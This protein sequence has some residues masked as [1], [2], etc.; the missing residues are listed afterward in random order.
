MTHLSILFLA[1]TLGQAPAESGWLNSVPHDA[2][3]VVRVRGLV[4]AKTDLVAMLKA[5]SP[6]LGAQAEP[7]L[8]Q[9]VASAKAHANEQAVTEPFMMMLRAVAPENPGAPPFAVIVKSTNY[10][11]VLKSIAGGNDPGI[12]HLDAGYDSFNGP[13]GETWYAAKGEG[14]VGFGPD[15]TLVAGY[16]KPGDKALGKTISPAVQKKFNTGDIGLYVNINALTTRY[17]EQVA[18]AKQ[19]LLATMDQVG[20]QLGAG[21][22]DFLKSVYGGMFDSIKEADVIALSLELGAEGLGVTGTLTVKAD[23]KMIK[24]I[25]GIQTSDGAGLGK[26]PV[27]SAYYLYMNVDAKTFQ[28]LQV[29]AL[30]M[31]APGGKI[32]PELEATIA[33]ERGRIESVA[34]FSVGNG[35]KTFDVTNLTDPKSFVD[36]FNGT[37]KL[38]QAVDSPSNFYKDF[39]TTPN[40]ET[41][42]GFT[43]T[44]IEMTFDFEKLAKLMPNNPAG[45]EGMKAMYGGDKMTT[46]LGVSDTQMIKANA[47][48]WSD[49]KAQIDSY[50]KGDDGI[51][52]SAGFK[53]TRAKLP[54]QANI[55]VLISAQGLVRQIM[56]Q[57]AMMMPNAPKQA[58][59]DMPKDPAFIG[60]SLTPSAPNGFEFRLVIP[61]TVGP[62]IEKGI[63]PLMPKAQPAPSL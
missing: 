28:S 25:A 29:M 23:S 37:M 48:T 7:A 42:R 1:A 45:I 53:A 39:K 3:V 24:S 19:G 16:T 46:W 26:L 50:F 2:D 43:F 63:M 52:A 11:A 36:A 55:L 35:I 51:G 20:G 31:M 17:A 57:M 59:A 38:M 60:V 34:C 5:M 13:G 10:E 41:Y 49:V 54:E 6:A 33:K 62:V 44:K 9:A 58:P 8:E 12:K 14:T 15:K 21:M 27:D 18:Q 4:A 56:A 47:A 61:S 32:S 22:G 40:V 30:Q